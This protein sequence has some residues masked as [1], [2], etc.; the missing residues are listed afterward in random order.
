MMT[1]PGKRQ[2]LIFYTDQG[3]ALKKKQV[4]L[5]EQKQSQIKE[6]DIEVHVYKIKDD[7][8]TVAKWKVPASA[9]FEFILV[10]KDGGEK[11]R[12]DTVVGMQQLFSV[13]DAMP[14]RKDE[15]KQSR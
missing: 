1:Y 6:R 4:A 15:M 8:A 7:K 12:A 14:M 10:G 11:L 3:S 9:S 13:I 5:L 2:V